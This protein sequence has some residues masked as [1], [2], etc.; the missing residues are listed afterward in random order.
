[1]APSGTS[2]DVNAAA[3]NRFLP[4]LAKAVLAMVAVLAASAPARAQEV[5]EEPSLSLGI[6]YTG[7]WR[8]NASG[9]MRVGTAYADALDLGLEWVTDGLFPAARLTTNVAVMQL[10]GRGLSEHY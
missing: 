7:D 4:G 3:D 8:R 6:A 1:M 9:G 10:G 2:S 5:V